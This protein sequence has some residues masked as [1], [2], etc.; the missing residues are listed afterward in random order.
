MP[1]DVV[2]IDMIA[3][4]KAEK[5]L[6]TANVGGARDLVTRA[7]GESV[8]GILEK[9]VT[10]PGEATVFLLDFSKIGII[11]YSCADEVVAKLV[12]RLVS[13]EYG[14]RYMIL[15]G[16][17][18]NQ[19]E[20]VEVA[21]ERKDLGVIAVISDS[22]AQSLPPHKGRAGVKIPQGRWQLIGSLNPYLTQTLNIVTERGRISAKE[23]GE[24]LKLEINAS[25]TRLI[26]LHKKH[27][28]VR[29]DEPLKDGG[30]QFVYESLEHFVMKGEG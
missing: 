9:Q 17:N 8:R 26:N 14:D 15:M 27:L 12:S 1:M 5:A 24:M 3:A 28:V 16:L 29:A 7:T 18:D 11:D 6:G 20:N 25:S 23:L 19:K 13:G 10:G 21:L 2:V 22:A 4:I 30:R